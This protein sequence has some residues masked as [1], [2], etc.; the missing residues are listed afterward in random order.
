M[1]IKKVLLNKKSNLTFMLLNLYLKDK[2]LDTTVIVITKSWIL[3]IVRLT[4]K[5]SGRNTKW[6]IFSKK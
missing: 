5:K 6:V 3:S 4:F 2:V 1:F